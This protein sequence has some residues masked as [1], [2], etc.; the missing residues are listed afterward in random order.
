MDC[1][2]GGVLESDVYSFQ[3]VVKLL[4]L[5]VAIPLFGSLSVPS[6]SQ[7]LVVLVH[8]WSVVVVKRYKL[9]PLARGQYVLSR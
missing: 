7:G 2:C 4:V 9:S 6:T 5:T 3:F 1:H 8:R